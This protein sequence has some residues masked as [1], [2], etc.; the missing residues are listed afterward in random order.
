MEASSLLPS[1][2]L[3][4][5]MVRWAR[6]TSTPTAPP[7]VSKLLS[8]GETGLAGCGLLFSSFTSMAWAWPSAGGGS[9]DWVTALPEGVSLASGAVAISAS[10]ASPTPWSDRPSSLGGDILQLVLSEVGLMV[11][12]GCPEALEI[13]LPQV[14]LLLNPL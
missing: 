7:Q 2:P 4:D 1:R 3:G 14:N 6:S 9:E 5:E 11:G 13:L 8:P 12:D 10:A